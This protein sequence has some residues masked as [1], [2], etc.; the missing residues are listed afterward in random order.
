M[1]NNNVLLVLSSGLLGALLVFVLGLW[2][3]RSRE[4]KELEGLLRLVEK[5]VHFNQNSRLP[6]LSAVKDADLQYWAV[7]RPLVAE[8]WQQARVR[9]AQLLR[10]V[11]NFNEL[12]DYYR[13]LQELND[14]LDEHASPASRQ[15]IKRR[16]IDLANKTVDVACGG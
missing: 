10:S 11:E 5:E 8:A 4:K 2:R 15:D 7:G 16:A 9:I 14:L 3:D 1:T 6:G 12:T 13:D